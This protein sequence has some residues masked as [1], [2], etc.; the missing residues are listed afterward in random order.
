MPGGFFAA[1]CAFFCVFLLRGGGGV[2][3]Y[4]GVG[5][6]GCWL[7]VFVGFIFFQGVA[8]RGFERCPGRLFLWCDVGLLDVE[9]A[10]GG[11]EVLG[12]LYGVLGGWC[13]VALLQAQEV[14]FAVLDEFCALEAEG[15]E[16]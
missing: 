13:G 9:V 5:C 3:Y 15:C 11:D 10:Q 6:C 7:T 4:G 2:L 12:T 16:V 8:C 14:F 1:G